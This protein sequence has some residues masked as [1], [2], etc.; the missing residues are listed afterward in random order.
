M[1]TIVEYTDRLST[2]LIQ[3]TPPEQQRSAER[4][5]RDLKEQ[6]PQFTL[7][8][9]SRYFLIGQKGRGGGEP[10]ADPFRAAFI[11][12]AMLILG[13]RKNIAERT[14][15]AWH[16]PHSESITSG[17]GE[18]FQPKFAKC[19]VTGAHLFGDAIKAILT[20]PNL[21]RKVKKLR[22][23]DNDEAEIQFQDVKASSFKIEFQQWRAVVHAVELDGKLLSAIAGMVSG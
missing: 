4:L 12:I 17:V 1:P 7:A 13:P 3:G 9:V 6:S 10:E 18:D 16:L 15:L 19:V 8:D 23:T 5:L 22:I 11:L 2:L 20:D 14:W 21:A